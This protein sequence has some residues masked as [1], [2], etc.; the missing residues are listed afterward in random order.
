MSTGSTQPFRVSGNATLA[1][2][3]ASA[4]V[5]LTGNGEAVLV[6]NASAAVAFVRFGMDATVVAGPADTPVPAGARMLIHAGSFALTA[7][8]LLSAGSGTVFFTRGDGT[9]Y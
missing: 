9:T 4:N 1:A 8:A 3:T 7:A 2:G 5:P 6:F